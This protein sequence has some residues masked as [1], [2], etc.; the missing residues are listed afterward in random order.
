MA[1]SALNKIIFIVL[2]FSLITFE[3]NIALELIDLQFTATIHEKSASLP[4]PLLAMH[5]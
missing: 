1:N 2:F 4:M 5:W 3:K